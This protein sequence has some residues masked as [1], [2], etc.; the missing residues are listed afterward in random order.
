MKS[1]IVWGVLALIGAGMALAG[2]GQQGATEA[3]QEQQAAKEQFLAERS[4]GTPVVSDTVRLGPDGRQMPG[5]IGT[6]DKIDG[7]TITVKSPFDGTSS[8]VQIADGAKVSKQAEGELSEIKVGDSVTVIGAKEGETLQADMIRLGDADGMMG[9][10]PIMFAG[11]GAGPGG[12]VPVDGS[13]PQVRPFNGG[14]PGGAGGAQGTAPGRRML[15]GEM[16]EVISG[17]VELI[18]GNLI[19]VKDKDGN[20]T[21]VQA[22][23]DAIVLKQVEITPSDLKVGDTIAANGTRNGDVLEATRVQVMPDGAMRVER[24]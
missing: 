12:N 11:P 14:A 22:K 3:T 21:T 8:T 5:V 10:G 2:C 24:P 1:V 23:D 19:T 9:G 20:S 6:V 17:T 15:G 18:E 16:P 13:Q 4:G 7:N